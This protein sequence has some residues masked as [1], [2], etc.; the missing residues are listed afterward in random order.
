MRQL[1]LPLLA[2][3]IAAQLA[4]APA[5]GEEQRA[6]KPYKAV[7]VVLPVAF[8]DTGFAA[9]RQELAAIAKSRVYAELARLITA[10]GFFWER[11]FASAFDRRKPAVDNLAAAIRLEHRSGAGWNALAAFAAEPTAAPLP[12]YAGVICAPRRPQFDEVEFDRLLKQTDTAE[13]DWA[14]PRADKTSARGAAHRRR[15][16]RNPRPA[17]RPAHGPRQQQETARAGKRSFVRPRN[18]DAGRHAERQDWFRLGPRTHG[19]R[20]PTALLPQG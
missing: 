13:S 12:S 14:Y 20:R 4:A 1:A 5:L 9:F 10:Q 18:M 16:D 17:F 15:S 3:L 2:L 11:D 7:P 8:E 19:A 6:P